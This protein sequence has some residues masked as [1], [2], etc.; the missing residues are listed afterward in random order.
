MNDFDFEG[1]N[2]EIN[3]ELDKIEQG[4][5]KLHEKDPAIQKKNLTKY[6]NQINWIR[7][8]LEEFE[9]ELIDLESADRQIQTG[10]HKTLEKRLNHIEELVKD[11]KNNVDNSNELFE[12]KKK[13]EID[14]L[15]EMGVEEIGRIG[16]KI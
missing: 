2:T 11:A 8:Q 12:T 13:I 3:A 6:A 16:D 10:I 15:E 9:I 7:L 5:L 14:D 1:N 4:L